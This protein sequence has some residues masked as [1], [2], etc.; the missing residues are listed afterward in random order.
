MALPNDL[1][2]INRIIKQITQDLSLIDGTAHCT[3]HRILGLWGFFALRVG[4]NKHG[5]KFF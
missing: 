3:G 1:A 2:R 5:I 4:L